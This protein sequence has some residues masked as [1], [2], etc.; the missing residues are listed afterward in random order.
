M[1]VEHE[2]ILA[3]LRRAPLH[4]DPARTRTYV[5]LWRASAIGSS[6]DMKRVM[7]RP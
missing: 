6:R 7:A 1:Q 4:H 2:A 3:S 5:P